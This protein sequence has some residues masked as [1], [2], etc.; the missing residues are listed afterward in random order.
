MAG[1]QKEGAE[2]F[3]SGH[4]L[5]GEAASAMNHILTLLSLAKFYVC[6]LTVCFGIPEAS[7]LDD[8]MSGNISG[9]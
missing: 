2:R 4:L 8:F 6:I 1:C 5:D 9:R 7:T 3:D